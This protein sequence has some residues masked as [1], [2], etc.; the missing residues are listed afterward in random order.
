MGQMAGGAETT[1][2]EDILY[3]PEILKLTEEAHNALEKIPIGE[4]DS[5]AVRL[6]LERLVYRSVR[7]W[8][9]E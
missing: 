7:A 6:I 4:V 2:E 9:G 8:T 3:N 1:L 5:D